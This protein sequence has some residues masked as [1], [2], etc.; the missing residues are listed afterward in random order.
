MTKFENAHYSRRAGVRR[1]RKQRMSDVRRAFL[2][3][4]PAQRRAARKNRL[5]RMR[6][7]SYSPAAAFA[8]AF[9]AG[10]FPQL[11]FDPPT[12][13]TTQIVQQQLTVQK[14]APSVRQRA[15]VNALRAATRTL[16]RINAKRREYKKALKALGVARNQIQQQIHQHHVIRALNAKRLAQRAQR[17]AA[18]SALLQH[19]SLRKELLTKIADA[20]RKG[21]L[22]GKAR[23]Q[24]IA[25]L[26]KRNLT[27]RQRAR[28]HNYIRGQTTRSKRH[29][30][31]RERHQE[32]RNKKARKA[33]KSKKSKKS[34]LKLS[35]K[36]QKAIDAL[37]DRI[38][39]A[40]KKDS[41]K[42][43]S[44]KKSSKKESVGAAA[45]VSTQNK[46]SSATS[47]K[48]ATVRA[49]KPVSTQNKQSASTSSSKAN[50]RA[51]APVTTQNKQS[52]STASAKAQVRSAAPVAIQNKSSAATS[53]SKANV[54]GS[55]PVRFQQ[56]SIAAK[57]AAEAE[58]AALSELNTETE[59][60]DLK[61]QP[62]LQVEAQVEAAARTTQEFLHEHQF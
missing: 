8:A 28:L 38:R 6:R 14:H 49:N 9:R 37:I 19:R 59:V 58:E 31:R 42:K 22:T 53:S 2:R 11:R 52:A 13:S 43:K 24:A 30:A 48:K 21:H 16:R 57:L 23:R 3:L 55:T 27:P 35:K 12:T 4:N 34:G 46:Q 62:L 47:S 26:I 29:Q 7:L 44:S 50:V 5:R 40:A 33:R 25:A 54:R 15:E 20:L 45:P 60:D 41:K 61:D 10:K 56:L 18:W 17:R 39:A 51:P 1:S 36:D 32:R